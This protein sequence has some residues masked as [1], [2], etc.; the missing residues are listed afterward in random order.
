ME[1]FLLVPQTM[2]AWEGFL[3]AFNS[4]SPA[5]QDFPLPVAR[6]GA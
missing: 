1:G 2:L 4:N 6:Q 3:L 5:F